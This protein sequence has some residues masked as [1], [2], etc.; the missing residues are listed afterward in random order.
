MGYTNSSLV[1]YTRISKNSNPRT[2]KICRISPH[3]MAGNLSVE[4]CGNVFANGS[5]SS[6]YGIGSDGRVAMYVEEKNRSWCTSSKDN[7]HKAVTIEV[8]N[9][10]GAAQGWPVTTEAWNSLAYLCAD[11]CRRNGKTKLLWFGDKN[12]TLAYNPADNEM[13][14]TVHRWFAAK[15][16]PGDVLYKRMNEL[17]EAVDKLIQPVPEAPAGP[18]VDEQPQPNKATNEQYLWDQLNTIIPND[19]GKAGMV[20]NL[21]AESGLI[22][23]NLQNSYEEKLG[24]SDLSYTAGVDSGSYTNF[25]NDKAGYGIA[26]WT[27]YTRKEDMLKFTKERRSSIGDFKTQVNFLVF[28]LQKNFK[29]VISKLNAAKSIKEASDIVLREFEKP[30]VVINGTASNATAA[31]KKKLEEVEVSRANYSTHFYNMYATNCKFPYT[32][33]V[34]CDVLN[35]RADASNEVTKI[36][37][38]TDRGIYTIL[39]EKSGPG[40]TKGWGKLK[41]GAGWISLDYVVKT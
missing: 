20:G 24:M 2:G 1:S 39:E 9:S 16:C 32:V 13:V 6:N 26:Q 4:T 41:S 23:I 28:E 3:C 33:R 27:Y 15:A 38:I 30:A 25:V 34:K 31:A 29:G 37:K 19:F 22:A 5:A 40:S 21:F 7:D 35:I 18:E 17:V 14:L 12:K 8:A 36:G 10:S 11:I